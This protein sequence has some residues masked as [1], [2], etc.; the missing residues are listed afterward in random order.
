MANKVSKNTKKPNDHSNTLRAKSTR[1]IRTSSPTRV[2]Q[3]FTDVMQGIKSTNFFTPVNCAAIGIAIIALAFGI[4][5]VI[6]N[7]MPKQS[8]PQFLP[9]KPSKTLL[10]NAYEAAA[11]EGGFS[12][13]QTKIEYSDGGM[14]QISDDGKVLTIRMPSE[15]EAHSKDW[16]RMLARAI[17]WI[18]G[19][20]NSDKIIQKLQ[21]ASAKHVLDYEEVK[22]TDDYISEFIGQIELTDRFSAVVGMAVDTNYPFN[23][24]AFYENDADL[25]SV[26]NDVC[27][28]FYTRSMFTAHLQFLTKDATE[29][30]Y[31][32]E[33]ID[34]FFKIADNRF[35]FSAEN[36]KLTLVSSGLNQNSMLR[37]ESTIDN[38]TAC[39]FSTMGIPNDVLKAMVTDRKNDWKSGTYYWGDYKVEVNYSKEDKNYTPYYTFSKKD[40]ETTSTQ[41][42]ASVVPIEHDDVTTAQIMRDGMM[43]TQIIIPV[44]CA[45]NTKDYTVNS[46]GYLRKSDG[47]TTRTDT[48]M[49]S[50][51]KYAKYGAVTCETETVRLKYSLPEGY[52]SH[53]NL[54]GA[55]RVNND[56]EKQELNVHVKM[57]IFADGKEGFYFSDDADGY[58]FNIYDENNKKAESFYIKLVPKFNNDQYNFL[59]DWRIKIDQ[60]AKM[61]KIISSVI[62]KIQSLT[63]ATKITLVT[64]GT[65]V[66]GSALAVILT[67]TMNNQPQTEVSQTAPSDKDQETKTENNTQLEDDS[68]SNDSDSDKGADSNATE[69]STLDAG[70][71]V[72]DSKPAPNVTPGS[73]MPSSNTLLPSNNNETCTI[74]EYGVTL[75]AD[76]RQECYNYLQCDV[77]HVPANGANSPNY[78]MCKKDYATY[79][80]NKYGKTEPICIKT[81]ITGWSTIADPINLAE[82]GRYYSNKLQSKYETPYFFSFNMPKANAF[83]LSSLAE[84]KATSFITSNKNI[85]VEMAASEKDGKW[86]VTWGAYIQK[87]LDPAKYGENNYVVASVYGKNHVK[88][89]ERAAIDN[90]ALQYQ[91]EIQNW[92]NIYAS[93]PQ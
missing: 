5:G 89:A 43:S 30:Y 56:E 7:L 80:C 13:A 34:K 41:E 67:S 88:S 8:S 42:K 47:S 57:S 36:S 63:L 24:Y 76:F 31:T 10:Q 25:L 44:S 87:Q 64:T 53:P 18:D 65:I 93:N 90:L 3:R 86:T 15:T 79:T 1:A 16:M 17:N 55:Y 39:T 22:D 75:S 77:I 62:V 74:Q 82:F 27:N 92:Q 45:W 32:P 60:G 37:G 70:T 68:S 52:T 48:T 59:R 66:A 58:Q 26:T 83:R 21:D 40:S 51:D 69:S 2:Q 85:I 38:L 91:N 73:N 11:E 20:I 49:G 4:Y 72:N 12:S 23:Y 33:L 50:N 9:T 35:V 14:M 46:S 71:Q 81:K 61:I 19:A 6:C 29:R 54:G 28:S 84:Q 78:S